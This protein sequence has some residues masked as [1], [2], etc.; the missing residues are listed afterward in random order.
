MRWFKKHIDFAHTSVYDDYVPKFWFYCTRVF[1]SLLLIV[2]QR[3]TR[4]REGINKWLHWFPVSVH[5]KLDYVLKVICGI[6]RFSSIKATRVV[7][8]PGEEKGSPGSYSSFKLCV[9]SILTILNMIAVLLNMM[10]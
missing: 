8:L 6:L 5:K 4:P 10:C 9:P 7:A 2:P 1:T 3:V